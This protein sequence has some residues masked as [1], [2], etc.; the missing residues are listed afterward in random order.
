MANS[1]FSGN[2][3]GLATATSPGLVGTG[4]QTF[5][6]DKTL[7]G[8]IT[9][10]GGIINTGLTGAN[11]TTVT[12]SG[13]SKVGETRRIA[14]SGPVAL[15]NGNTV[16]AVSDTL[17]AGVWLCFVSIITTV[18]ANGALVYHNVSKDLTILNEKKVTAAGGTGD[19][20]IS[21]FT[22]TIVSNGSNVI[23]GKV[24]ATGTVTGSTI[25]A[26]AEESYISSV[27]IA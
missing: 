20:Q 24:Q 1:A 14:A 17:P 22:E 23:A 13:S 7:T 21:T 27:R 5:A 18:S 15:V 2:V 3:Q 16:T 25:D 6:G 11:A 9:A 8:L 19:R 10:S 12:T 26:S 4:A